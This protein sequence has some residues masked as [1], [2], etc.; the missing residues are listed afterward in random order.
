MSKLWPVMLALSVVMVFILTSC[1]QSPSSPPPSQT[2]Q[3]PTQAQ[4]PGATQN[5]SASSTVSAQD[6]NGGTLKIVYRGAAVSFGYPPKIAGL[7]NN[8]AKPFF[9][10]L[11]EEGD[12]GAYT[13]ELAT[14]WDIA[15]D[16]KSIIFHLRQSVKFQDGTDFNAQAVKFNYDLLIPPNPNILA[17]VVSV[18]A[19]DNNTVKINLS[20][21]NNLILYQLASDTRCF[22]DSPTAIQKNGADWAAINPCG[23][24][25]FKL[26]SYE[27]NVSMKLTKFADYWDKSN[28]YLDGIQIDSIADP[29]TAMVS[30]KSGQANMLWA[31][32]VTACDQLAKTGYSVY[33]APGALH[34]IT[35]DTTRSDSIFSNPKVRQAIEYAVDKEAIC[36]GPGFGMYKPWNQMA[37]ENTPNYN[38][39][40]TPRKYDPAKAKQLLGEAGFANGLTFSISMSPSAW[41][42]GF[43][44][45]QSYLSQVGITMNIN[46][47]TAAVY[48]GSMKQQGQLDKNSAAVIIFNYSSNDL[49]TMNS[50]LTTKAPF[51]Q[52][53]TRP[54]GI[55]DLIAQAQT[56]KDPK[57]ATKITQQIS[58]LIYDDETFVPLWTE[59]RSAVSDKSVQN[60]GFFVNGSPNNSQWGRG[61]WLKK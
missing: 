27:R 52:N 28:I 7:D 53:M 22:I 16:S 42:D 12:G 55:D 17:G 49:L 41:K 24:G 2:Q 60:P 36:S 1:T 5:P 21:F 51:F 35:F 29:M 31:Q 3:S 43:T 59:P 32:D 37:I 45:V 26:A 48:E 10:R 39:A 46:L 11:L 20:N 8:Y 38:L 15:P 61:L 19:I 54:K 50:F 13:P 14:S 34:G 18:E 56:Q 25:P 33:Q 57:E 30:L 6:K 58:K 44:A 23:T 4:K 9:D 47:V 40:L